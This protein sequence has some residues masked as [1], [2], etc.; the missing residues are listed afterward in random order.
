MPCRRM[1]RQTPENEAGVLS[2]VNVARRMSPGCGQS[3]FERSKRRVR[4][5]FGSRTAR[6]EERTCLRGSG[7]FLRAEGG[8]G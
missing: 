6:E 1:E 8:G 3:G 4:E 5:E 2:G 7:Y